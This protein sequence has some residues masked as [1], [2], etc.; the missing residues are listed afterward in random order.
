MQNTFYFPLKLTTHLRRFSLTTATPGL[1]SHCKFPHSCV[2]LAL[3]LVF[4]MPYL[5]WIIQYIPYNVVKQLRYKNFMINSNSIQRVTDY[6]VRMLPHYKTS[7]KYWLNFDFSIATKSNRLKSSCQI[8]RQWK[9]L[10]T[11]CREKLDFSSMRT[12]RAP[13]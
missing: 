12:V 6:S 10:Q 5:C 13:A 4:Q 11:N 8:Y 7:W 3:Y 9:L 1:C 2:L